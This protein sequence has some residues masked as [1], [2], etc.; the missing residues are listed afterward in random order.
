MRNTGPV[1]TSVISTPAIAGPTILARLKII[2]LRATALGNWSL[3]T[4]SM[5]NDCRIGASTADTQ[6]TAS[7]RA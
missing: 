6:P 7:A 5:V 4:I 3:P 2:E 1:P